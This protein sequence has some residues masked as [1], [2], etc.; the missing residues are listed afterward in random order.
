M[1][2]ETKPRPAPLT[3][4][5]YPLD[6]KPGGLHPKPQPPTPNPIHQGAGMGMEITPE[7]SETEITPEMGITTEFV[8]M[9]AQMMLREK[10]MKGM[11]PNQK[12]KMLE[13]EELW[14]S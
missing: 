3:P 12:S 6:P 2:M 7:M 11:T 10:E 13:M 4:A 8:A 1:G 14:W 5:P 9:S